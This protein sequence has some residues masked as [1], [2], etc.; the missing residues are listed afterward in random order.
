MKVPMNAQLMPTVVTNRGG[1]VDQ[2][3]GRMPAQA[4]SFARANRVTTTNQGVAGAEEEARKLLQQGSSAKHQVTTALQNFDPRAENEADVRNRKAQE[5]SAL[6]RSALI[7]N[8]AVPLRGP[9]G[10]SAMQLFGDEVNR[11]RC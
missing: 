3:A 10:R 11:P 9:D 6:Y 4:D 2:Q 1:S 8:R 5:L 7:A